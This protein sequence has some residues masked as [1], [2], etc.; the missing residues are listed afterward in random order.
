ML[1]ELQREIT[2]LAPE[3]VLL[4]GDLIDFPCGYA[5]FVAFCRSLA[6]RFPVLAVPGNHDRWAGL[7][8]LKRHLN[9]VRWL[10]EEPVIWPN[11]LRLCGRAQQGGT[12]QSVLVGHEPNRVAQAARFG[13]PLMLAG[14]LHGCQW[15]AFQKDGLDYPGAWF[16]AY[17][18]D[19]FQVGPTRLY[20]SRGVSDT[21]PIRINC[22]RDYLWLQIE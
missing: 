10:D 7:A 16:F 6:N 11:G 14:H 21:L 17:H 12:P 4:G 3:A 9:E 1:A 8:R 22:P 13:F 20:V 15:I 19:Y 2:A 5:N 18:G